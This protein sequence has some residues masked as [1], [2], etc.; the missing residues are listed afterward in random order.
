MSEIVLA[1]S[2]IDKARAEA[3]AK[4]LGA[5]GY[6]VAP[7][8][9]TAAQVDAAK[10]L[11]VFWSSGSVNSLPINQ[12][13]QQAALDK[14]LVSVRAGH[15]DPP[16]AFALV[17]LHDL[18]RWTGSLEAPELRTFL[19]HVLRKAPPDR[20]PPQ[21]NFAGALPPREPVSFAPNAAF[22][23]A[24]P[25]GASMRPEA[26]R[27]AQQAAQAQQA[28]AAP[29]PVPQRAPAMVQPAP[30][31][32]ATPE[33]RRTPPRQARPEPTRQALRERPSARRAEER[34]RASGGGAARV[35]FGAIAVSVIAG[36]AVAAFNYDQGQQTAAAPQPPDNARTEI[37]VT[38]NTFEP[39]V[40]SDVV[41]P[42]AAGVQ[43]ASATPLPAPL[44][45]APEPATPA[46]TVQSS[47]GWT[48]T[49]PTLP[50]PASTARA[51][52]VSAG[53]PAPAPST[54]QRPPA[55]LRGTAKTTL[56]PVDAVPMRP[57]PAATD[58]VAIDNAN[59][60][61]DE[62]TGALTRT[63]TPDEER[64][65]TRKN[66]EYGPER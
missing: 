12:F 31:P 39:P 4:V 35:A 40:T 7:Q 23:F 32:E 18:S 14:K 41:E 56:T 51:I 60:G 20:A 9:V 64:G 10:A 17:A 59:L 63:R 50:T 26:Q 3:V 15:A 34:R 44:A 37:A 6:T 54:A 36:A 61:G 24:G 43:V 11:I 29:A 2:S 65:W 53:A 19:Q 33:A 30:E 58:L 47:R 48:A 22:N 38:P 52:P 21:P 28:A 57:A 5:L 66:T 25:A 62:T 46:A 13:A 42:V 45:A 16:A 49:L 55:A 27:A 8:P 1:Y